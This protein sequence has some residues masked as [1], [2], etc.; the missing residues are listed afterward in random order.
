[1]SEEVRNI[2]MD[3]AD[4]YLF[5]YEIKTKA[6]GDELIPDICPFCQG[7]THNHDKKTFAVSLENG[8]YV[9]KR[10]S[11]GKRG[12]LESLAEFFNE[13]VLINRKNADGYQSNFKNY[14]LPSVKMLPPTE[15]IYQYCETRK[16]SRKTVDAFKLQ[17]DEKGNIV[18]PFYENGENVFVK[19]RK[20]E[21][22]N[23]NDKS[24]KEWRES[25]T[26]PILFGMDM[27]VFSRPLVI[28]EGEFDCMALYE[29]GIDNVVSVPS[30][31]EDFTWVENC[32][33]WLEKFKTIILFGDN[34]EPGRKMVKTLAKRLDESRCRIVEDYPEYAPGKFCKDANEILVRMGEFALIDMVENARDV[35]VK[36][37]IDLGS[38]PPE[39]PTLVPR[40]KT[41]IPK[42]DEVT[43]GLLEGGISIVLGKAGSGKSCLSNTITLN[44]LEQGYTV[45][46]YTG[47]FRASRYQ[48][49]IHLQAAGS[50]Y[51]SL[52]YDP[53]K[54]KKVPY[55]PYNV[56]DR[57]MNW[58]KGRLLLYDNEETYDG[59]QA[60]AVLNVFTAAVRRYDAK[61]LIC[62]NLMTLTSDQEDE[63]SAQRILA[64]KLKRFANK[65]GVAI[66][67]VAHARK[68]KAGE[69]L[70]ADDLSGSSATNNLADM[71]LSVEPGRI[72]ILK[73]RDEGK[74]AVIEF[75]YCPDSR[76][77]YQADAGD[78]MKLSWDKTGLPAVSPRADS[79]EEYQVVPPP[80]SQPF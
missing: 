65:Y 33:D 14:V 8:C 26:K 68:T 19:F 29:A 57:I 78:K 50:E 54:G 32:Y 56:Q 6:H 51:I 17:S 22:H 30:G 23:P 10:G 77:L 71:T 67:L 41:N 20:P 80:S 34:D 15:K 44:A 62:D 27:C 58:Y 70:V 59:D 37:L 5:P 66:L 69:S 45:C 9:C 73:N 72:H 28:T 38:L 42:L 1:M 21:K 24:P 63:T 11:C 39:D 79:L 12:T 53:V 46:V 40:I 75:C 60:D 35:P 48:Y 2:V 7:G 25:N 3:L 4:K 18:F 13:K 61:L 47:E 43:G 55:V 52:K 36:G 16:I 74:N 31:C 49:W 64:N 76:R